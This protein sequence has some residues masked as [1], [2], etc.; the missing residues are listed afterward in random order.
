MDR[1]RRREWEDGEAEE[2]MALMVA[3]AAA[4]ASAAAAGVQRRYSLMWCVQINTVCA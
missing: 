1:C 4:A 2:S 3:L